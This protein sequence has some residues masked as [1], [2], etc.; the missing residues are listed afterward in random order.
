[1]VSRWN[2]I[3]IT[4]VMFI[5]F[6]LFQFTNVMLERWNNYE[7]NT[8]VRDWKELPGREDA[9]AIERETPF[10]VYRNQ[11]VYIGDA[12]EKIGEMV[13]TWAAYSKWGMQ[14]FDSVESYETSAR[15]TGYLAPQI[16]AI[17]AAQTDWKQDEA[18]ECLEK[19]A[20]E[21]ITI[22][23][24]NL[25]DVTVIEKSRALRRLLGIAEVREREIT[26]EGLYLYD[27]FLLGGEALYRTEDAS[28]NAKKQDMELT[29]PW[30]TLS[31]DA[32]LYMR[33][34]LGDESKER[35]EF[36]AVIWR[37]GKAGSCVYA[38]NGD[39]MEDAAGLGLLTAMWSMSKGYDIYPVVNAQNLVVVN[40]P[41][42]S[43]E[44]EE[45]VRQRYGRNVRDLFRDVV[46]PSLVSVYRK[47]TLGLSC[48]IAPQFDYNDDNLPE[49]GQ[50]L[51]YMRRINEEKAEAGLS[52]ICV[53]DTPI[54]QKLAEDRRLME[55]ALPTYHFTSFYVGN[56][57]EREVETALQE[58]FLGTV[59]TIVADYAGE[60]DVIAYQNENVTRQSVLTDGVRHTYR[61]D[62]R[63]KGV[64]TALGYAVAL[65]DLNDVVYSADAEDILTESISS[66]QWNVQNSFKNFQ[67]FEGTTLSESDERIRSF[68]SLDYAQHRDDNTI[69]VELDGFKGSAWF[70]LRCG[71]DEEVSGI[72]GGTFKLLEKDVYL[73]EAQNKNMEITLR[74]KSY[75]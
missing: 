28:E 23:F 19:C 3:A 11:I 12:D 56:F 15:G 38:V 21:G 24:C 14:T 17:N 66:L 5:T 1:M 43:N 52:A 47:N 69:Y 27:G 32:S 31:E 6:F 75:F 65:A 25:P 71:D 18:C 20:A 73:I 36:P 42:L 26:V 64:E 2:Y 68:L 50:L 10:T 59:R 37:N 67:E 8:Y 41:G 44:N 48:M 72:N 4:V 57:E 30:Y 22:V 40:Y 49:Q 63:V 74:L 70:V 34:V 54:R 53:S 9:Y 29:F 46:W 13:R 45:A 61:E 7:E 58:E 33:G 60:S 62:F 16:I 55:K 35:E 51:Y 39:Y